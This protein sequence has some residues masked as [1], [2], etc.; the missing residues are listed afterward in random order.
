MKTEHAK[1]VLAHQKDEQW[2][3][4]HSW[5]EGNHAGW[6]RFV[7][8]AKRNAHSGVRTFF[9]SAADGD[10]SPVGCETGPFATAREAY[11]DAM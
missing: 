2:L 6:D 1:R 11:N 3:G 7:V 5:A 8:Y 9:W 4:L 10:G